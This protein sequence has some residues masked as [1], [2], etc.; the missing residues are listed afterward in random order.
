[1]AAMDQATPIPRK[2]F[3]ALL[4]VTLPIDASAYW[5][6]VAATLLANVSAE[7]EQKTMT[8]NSSFKDVFGV[9]GASAVYSRMKPPV[10]TQC[11]PQ[12]FGVVLSPSGVNRT[13]GSRCQDLGAQRWL[14][15]RW[16]LVQFFTHRD[17]GSL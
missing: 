1:M 8:L 14:Y 6:W 15:Y 3:T 17:L 7:K 16:I 4:P 2:T 5:S 12:G 13:T 10:E 11:L 9:L